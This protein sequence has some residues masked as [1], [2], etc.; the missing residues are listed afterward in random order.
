MTNPKPQVA[1]S[2]LADSEW[3]NK[4]LRGFL[5]YRDLGVAAVTDGRFGAN[6]ARATTAKKAADH[7][8]LHYHTLGFHLTYILRGWMRTYYEGVGEIVLRAGDCVTYS[9]EVVQSHTE[10]SEDFEVLQVT[11]PAEFPTVQIESKSSKS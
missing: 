11:M 5:K 3:E 9:G 2:R 7:A 1:V 6:V 4:G 8:G 10:H